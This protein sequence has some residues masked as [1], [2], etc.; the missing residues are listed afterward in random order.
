MWPEGGHDRRLHPAPCS[1]ASRAKR[2]DCATVSRVFERFA[3]NYAL[4][5]VGQTPSAPFE[6]PD[7]LNVRGYTAFHDSE[8]VDEPDAT[9][10][11]RLFEQWRQLH[12]TWS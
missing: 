9:V 1:P 4:L 11:I 12:P 8:L 3:A 6:D 10:V 5:P 2:G 7:L